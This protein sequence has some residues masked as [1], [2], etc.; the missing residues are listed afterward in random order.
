MAPLVPE[1][2][3]QLLDSSARQGNSRIFAMKIKPCTSTST[4]GW[5]P[6]EG[7][8]SERFEAVLRSISD[9][10]FTIDLN[11]VITCFNKAAEE[12]TGFTREEAIGSPCHTVFQTDLCRDACTLRYTIEHDTPIVD[13][14]VQRPSRPIALSSPPPAGA[15]PQGPSLCP[16]VPPRSQSAPREPTK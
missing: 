6:E 4:D 9:G 3:S 1:V 10:V 15:H 2:Q 8:S 16:T 14:M 7:L 13:L 5:L 12:I 11:G